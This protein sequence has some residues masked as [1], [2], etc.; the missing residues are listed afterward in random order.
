MPNFT[1]VNP[2]G[3]EIDYSEVGDLYKWRFIETLDCS[4]ITDTTTVNLS[5]YNEV[6]IVFKNVG[7]SANMNVTTAGGTA[8][9]YNSTKE[10]NGVV[11]DTMS[12]D[13]WIFSQAGFLNGEIHFYKDGTYT[14]WVGMAIETGNYRLI[15]GKCTGEFTTFTFPSN[16]GNIEVYAR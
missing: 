14:S 1:T 4:T 10:D 11:T 15:G 9:T 6:K 8:G 13:Y 5:G 12:F 16:S 3:S 2:F 7:H